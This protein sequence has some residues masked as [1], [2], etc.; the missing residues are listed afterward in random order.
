MSKLKVLKRSFYSENSVKVAKKLLGKLLV[1]ELPE[2]KLI[3]KIVEVEAYR[4]SDDPASHAYRGKTQRN[5]VMFSKPGLAYIY[6]IYGVHY[7]LN[8]K[9]EKE[10]IPGA[11]LIRALEPIEGI[12]IMRKNR[13]IEKITELTNGPAKLTEA[14]KIT[15]ELNGWD[16]TLGKRL[17]ICEPS[18]KEDFEIIATSRIGIKVGTEKPW[19]FYIK[20]NAYVSIR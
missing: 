16:L 6:L 9:A 18:L 13:Q 20:G 12:E 4:G 7:C 17:F 19:R 8:V 14:M 1:R 2:G 5:Q 11:V 10:G 3:G 15:G